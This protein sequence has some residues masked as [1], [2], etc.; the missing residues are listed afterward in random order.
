MNPVAKPKRI[1]NHERRVQAEKRAR[2]GKYIWTPVGLL[3]GILVTLLLNQWIGPLLPG[4]SA[5]VTIDESTDKS[6][7][8]TTYGIDFQPDEEIDSAYVRIAFPR[9]IKA[10]QFGY[11]AERVV[12]QPGAEVRNLRPGGL[13]LDEGV[14][15]VTENEQMWDTGREPGGECTLFHTAVDIT[16]GVSTIATANVLT[17]RTSKIAKGKP[18][19]GMVVVSQYET[20]L[21]SGIPTVEGNYEYTKWGLSGIKRKFPSRYGHFGRNLTIYVPPPPGKSKPK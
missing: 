10:S 14:G 1:S 5:L 15:P 13:V 9:N 8:C 11:F 21:T 2:R 19:G 12:G 16:E 17:I 20:A 18:V 7:G 3:I 4:P 6:T